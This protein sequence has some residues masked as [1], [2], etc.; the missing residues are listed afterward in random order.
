MRAGS[1]LRLLHSL[2]TQGRRLAQQLC[3]VAE[4]E[5]RQRQ[6]QGSGTAGGSWGAAVPG[7]MHTCTSFATRPEDARAAEESEPWLALA[8]S[9]AA[10]EAS[11][12]GSGG[13]LGCQDLQLSSTALQ[14]AVHISQERDVARAAAV[15]SWLGAMAFGRRLA[16]HAAVAE[17]LGRAA[18][19]RERQAEV[20]AQQ[21]AAL[22]RRASSK[23][24]LLAEQQAAVSERRT[25][26]AA[27]RAQQE[28]ADRQMQAHAALRQHSAAVAELEEALARSAAMSGEPPAAVT[29][30]TAAATA[31][32]VGQEQEQEASQA[33]GQPTAAAP[34]AL[35]APV[36]LP[37]AASRPAAGLPTVRTRSSRPRFQDGQHQQ[38]LQQRQSTSGPG[39]PP[40]GPPGPGLHSAGGSGSF[41]WA[42]LQPG[43]GVTSA[44]A[45]AATLMAATAAAAA[46]V[47]G[48]QEE[49]GGEPADALAPL[50]AVLEA[51]VTQSVQSQYRAASRA[52]VRWAVAACCSRGSAAILAGLASPAAH[53]GV[54]KHRQ[55]SPPN[56]E[57]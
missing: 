43:G 9:A 5:L 21:A 31:A 37:L 42:M 48:E 7:A 24:Q 47:A 2:E 54:R 27:Q 49:E 56:P 14:R 41:D 53:W 22:S 34:A 52:C 33:Q 3:D 32:T 44:S 16:E 23:S 26:L 39:R 1:Q 30:A 50:S 11:A 8:G 40:L 13:S 51:S 35:D 6:Q 12:A 29:A 4:Q 36:M 46:A 38:Q 55:H 19:Q 18:A 25:R 57:P 10:A 45:G 28:A 20:A 15:A 17:Q